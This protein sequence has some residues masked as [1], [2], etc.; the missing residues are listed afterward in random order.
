VVINLCTAIN[1]SLC[2]S[3]LATDKA[4]LIPLWM[5]RKSSFV[6]FQLVDLTRSLVSI[7]KQPHWIVLLA[8]GHMMLVMWPQGSPIPW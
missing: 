7:S 6:A 1:N 8:C 5:C 4:T 3:Y 2:A